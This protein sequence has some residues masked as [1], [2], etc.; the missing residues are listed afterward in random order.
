MDE[1]QIVDQDEITDHDH[2]P[3]SIKF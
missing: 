3:I 1:C 2:V